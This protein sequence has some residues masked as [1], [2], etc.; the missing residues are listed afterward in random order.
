MR[1]T[2]K[3]LVAVLL[4][5]AIVLPLLVGVYDRESP[6]LFGFPFFYWFQ[7]AL[8]PV[9]SVCTYI[10]YR[11]VT[12]PRRDSAARTAERTGP[13]LGARSADDEQGGRR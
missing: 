9:A 13:A 12:P 2:T 5:L 6:A 8:I 4:G 1:Y 3:L 11:L 7:F 10:A